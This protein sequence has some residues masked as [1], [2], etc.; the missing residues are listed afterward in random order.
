MRTLNLGF[1]GT[2][3]I[4]EALVTGFCEANLPELSITVSPRNHER[5][6]ALQ[7]K[8]P[9]IVRIATDN[10]N[11]VNRA[12]WLFFAVLPEV[13]DT[14]LTGLEIPKEK[15]F[16]NLV[17]TFSTAQ[18]Q[19]II[20]ERA[21][22]ADV[23]PLTFAADRFG[24]IVIYVPGAKA[25]DRQ[26]VAN[27]MLYVGQPIVV[28]TAQQIAVLRAMTA[29]MSPYYML[30]SHW[31]DWCAQN[32][33]SKKEAKAYVTAFTEALSQYAGGKHGSLA[34]LARDVTPGGLNWRTLNELESTRYVRKTIRFGH[35]G[36][37]KDKKI[38][39][40]FDQWTD[41]LNP[42]LKLVIKEDPEPPIQK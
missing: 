32:G 21:V 16:I 15:R 26:A 17:S 30:L 7:Q 5:A 14:V 4:S 27:L 33:V 11:V 18:I 6:T 40:L 36:Q 20:G 22:I 19:K 12:D 8:Y 35:L 29:M 42:I 3:L 25:N 41:V 38:G 2:G 9:K 1:I 31:I 23:V 34:L 37:R 24:P 28:K 39:N 10:Q 13:A